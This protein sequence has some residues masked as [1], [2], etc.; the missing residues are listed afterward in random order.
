MEQGI[1]GGNGEAPFYQVM[2]TEESVRFL[3]RDHHVDRSWQMSSSL[4]GS[5][6]GGQRGV[7]H[8]GWSVASK[9]SRRGILIT[10][11]ESGS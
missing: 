5:K 8:H 9:S 2:S 7:T 1:G 6:C 10:T 11:L 4:L 3:S